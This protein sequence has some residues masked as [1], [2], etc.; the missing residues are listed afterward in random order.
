MVDFENWLDGIVST[1]ELI[2][3]K[4]VFERVWVFGDKTI[5]SIHYPEELFEQLLGD[6]LSEDCLEHFQDR[7]QQM[8]IY[9]ALLQFTEALLEAKNAINI[10]PNLRDPKNFLRSDEWARVKIAAQQLLDFS[11]VAPYRNPISD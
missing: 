7:S 6:L 3:D 2:T 1:C 9:E 11:A 5:T 8:G 10:H 4:D